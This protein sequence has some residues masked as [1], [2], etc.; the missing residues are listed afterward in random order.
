MRILLALPPRLTAFVS[1]GAAGS[2]G[3]ADT[4]H[5]QLHGM[6]NTNRGG[7]WR[8]GRRRCSGCVSTGLVGVSETRATPCRAAAHRSVR[9]QARLQVRGCADVG[10]VNEG[11]HGALTLWLAFCTI[12]K[13]LNNLILTLFLDGSQ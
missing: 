4:R 9:A 5:E 3:S 6:T 8:R 2:G 11:L 7:H 12:N 10:T 1:S 13:I